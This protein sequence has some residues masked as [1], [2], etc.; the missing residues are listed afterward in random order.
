[1]ST[2]TMS[3][4]TDP[5]WLDRNEYPVESNYASLGPGT[6][7]YVDE[8]DGRPIVMLHGNPTWSFLYRHLIDGFSGEY[9]CIVPDYFG[10][11]LSEKPPEWSYLPRDHARVIEQLLAELDVTDVTL[12]VHDWGGPI[13]F[14]YASVHPDNVHSLVIMDTFM[15]PFEGWGPRVFSG[16]LGGPLGRLLIRRYNFFAD[17]FMKLAVNERLPPDVH[18][19]YTAPLATPQDRKGSWVFPREVTGSRDWLDT[20]WNR[21]D[22]IADLPALL[23][24]GM[25]D[26]VLGTAER[27]RFQALFPDAR[28]VTFENAGHYVPEERGREIVPEIEAF[29]ADLDVPENDP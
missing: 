14:N 24:W 16:L 17:V 18:R 19:H 4:T 12:V 8:G 5:A 10:F 29:F 2:D 7:H 6:L 25:N 23:C 28:T 26:P 21:R 20:L 22:A 11:G 9:R 1:M 27:R 13:G 15:W 3:R